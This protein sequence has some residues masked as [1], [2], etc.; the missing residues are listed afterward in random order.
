MISCIIIVVLIVAAIASVDR[1]GKNCRVFGPAG[2]LQAQ[3]VV[4]KLVDDP[5]DA[6]RIWKEAGYR[7]RTMVFVADKW[8]SFDPGEL[9]PVQMFRAYPLQLYNTARLLNDDYLNSV[10]FLYVASMNKICRRIA[11]IVPGN[12]VTRIKEAARLVKN[13][14][15]SDKGVYITRQGFPRWFTTGENFAGVGEPALLYIGASYFRTVEPEVLYRQLSASGL[16]ADCV[17]LCNEKGKAT[18]TMNEISK[19]NRFA[20]L[21]GLSA[22]PAK[23][24]GAQTSK[25]LMWPLP[26]PSK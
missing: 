21:I 4:K 11:A 26:V 12:E 17:I 16:Q 5:T 14:R 22:A 3:Q 23:S 15:V 18:V 24:G 13:S 7:G 25:A 10:T 8:E 9:I 1:Y 2:T 20:Q 6:Y 19:L